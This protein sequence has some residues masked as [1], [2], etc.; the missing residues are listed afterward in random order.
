MAAPAPSQPPSTAPPPA[1]VAPAV[2]TQGGQGVTPNP[3][4]AAPPVAA[5]AQPLQPMHQPP[6]MQQPPQQQM[7]PPAPAGAAPGHPMPTHYQ[8]QSQPMQPANPLPQQ[9]VQPPAPAQQGQPPQPMQQ[10]P[11]VQ[12]PP[13]QRPPAGAIA[14]LVGGWQSDKDIA[15]R[16]KMIAKM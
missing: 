15:D 16:R 9:Q 12:H 5:V 13:P 10:P 1:A 11:P 14:P 3:L 4:P 2:P 7:P 6:A 8:H